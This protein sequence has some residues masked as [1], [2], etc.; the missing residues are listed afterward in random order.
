VKPPEYVLGGSG[1]VVLNKVE[2][3]DQITE[4]G[5]VPR[6]EEKS[7][8]VAEDLRLQQVGVVD[9]GEDFLHSKKWELEVGS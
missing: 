7:S 5:L 9:F 3:A 1:V 8:C 6:L 4:G 2:V